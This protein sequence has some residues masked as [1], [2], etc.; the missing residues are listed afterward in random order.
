MPSSNLLGP[1]DI[2]HFQALGLSHSKRFETKGDLL[3]E[4]FEEPL[5]SLACLR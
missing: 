4:V 3:E 5:R 2:L 1:G